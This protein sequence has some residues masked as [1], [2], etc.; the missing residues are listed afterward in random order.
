MTTDFVQTV[1]SAH[2]LR[3]SDRIVLW[4][5]TYTITAHGVP[6]PGMI[7][8]WVS[9]EPNANGEFPRNPLQEKTVAR[10]IEF[11]LAPTK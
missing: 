8:L 1:V 5:E 6:A 3:A 10:D 11:Q 2:A 9:P 4:D 7:K